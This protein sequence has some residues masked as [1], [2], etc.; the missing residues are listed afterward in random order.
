MGDFSLRRLGVSYLLP[1]SVMG[2][3]IRVCEAHVHEES[4]YGEGFGVD[5]CDGF[6][7]GIFLRG[8]EGD[9]VLDF[10]KR[11]GDCARDMNKMCRGKQR[12]RI[13]GFLGEGID[14]KKE[15]LELTSILIYRMLGKPESTALTVCTSCAET[16]YLNG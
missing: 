5:L 13:V 9:R 14:V 2:L 15:T 10:V 11:H 8:G 1:S 6:G 3:E 7:D 4:W 16:T 12:S